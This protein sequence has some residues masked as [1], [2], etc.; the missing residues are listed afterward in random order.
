M[1]AGLRTRRVW[2]LAMAHAVLF[3]AVYWLAYLLRFDF[4]VKPDELDRYLHTLPWLIG[5]KLAVFYLTGHFQGWWR[6]V[7][8]ADL[9]ALI[10]A[11]VLSLLAV[12]AINFF[13]VFGRLT[14]RIPRSVLILDA[15]LGLMVLG[16]LR[17]SWRIFR[18]HFWPVIK[19]KKYHNALLVGTDEASAILAHQMQALTQLP[20]RILG[21]LTTNGDEKRGQLGQI[22]VLGHMEEVEKIAAAC[23]A[24][25]VFVVAGAL[26]GA[27]LRRLMT[28]CREADLNLKIVPAFQ[29]RLHGDRHVPVRNIEIN[30]L[31]GREPVRLDCR[32]IA[33]LL[34]G[35]SAM[36]TGAGGSIGSEICRQAILF[37]P[38][39]LILV[40]RGENRIFDVE[41]ELR[42][43]ARSTALH[44]Y[45][46]D[47]TDEVRMPCLFA[48]HRPEVVFHAAAHKHVPLMEANVAEAVRNNVLGTRRLA[49]LAHRF[50]VKS[51]VFI[52]TDKAVH[53]TSV[54]G[55]TKQLAERYVHALSQESQTRFSVV[56]FG[57]VLG[58]T[59]SVVP[60]FQDQIR[61]GGPITVTDPR[62]TRFFMTIPEASQLVLQ[63]AAMGRG[64]EIFVLEMGLPIR[65]VDLAGDLIRLSGLPEQAIEIVY[66]GLRPGEKLYE[67]LYFEDEATLPTSHEKVRVAYHRPYSVEEV[68]RAIGELLKLAGQSDDVVRRKLQEIIPEYRCSTAAEG[69]AEGA[70]QRPEEADAPRSR[71]VESHG[72]A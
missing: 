22:P 65:I 53:P 28:I 50:G 44:A 3:A 63:A 9:V 68:G 37:R 38:R 39:E 27:Q 13:G 6:Y 10:R 33:G 70:V 36:V 57:N 14:F 64:G 15:L 54:M 51:F 60:L 29:A 20:C 47:V 71:V 66:T 16:S 45:I 1:S 72:A 19:A 17:S 7:T 69:Q 59:G 31:L 61:R 12:A 24:T 43:A 5:V 23:N 46:A 21:L 34:E 26:P 35:R 8:F 4:Q 11:T 32:E 30:D 41:R 18:E 25:D 55:A 2:L 40:G 48:K 67:Q 52:S 49:D 42:S 56:R 62:M 58:S